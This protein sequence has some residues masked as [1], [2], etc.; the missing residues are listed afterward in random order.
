MARPLAGGEERRILPCVTAF[1]W[2]V[3]PGGI[4]HVHCGTSDAT[5]S[6]LPIL[7]FWNAA[8]G[9]DRVIATAGR[10]RGRHYQRLTGRQ[11]CSV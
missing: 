4:F 11:E 8:T 7:R 9:E 3:A 2:A 5:A 6:R 10:H 1:G